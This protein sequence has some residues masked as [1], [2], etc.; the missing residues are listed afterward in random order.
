MFKSAIDLNTRRQISYLRATM[1]YP[2]FLRHACQFILPL[3]EGDKQDCRVHI[4]RLGPR[5]DASRSPTLQN[6]DLNFINRLTRKWCLG[7]I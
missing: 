1:Y 3:G 7:N 5:C 2:L 4:V 6:D